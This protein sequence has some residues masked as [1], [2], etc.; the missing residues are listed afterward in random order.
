MLSK[1]LEQGFHHSAARL[2][3]GALYC[4]AV[5]FVVVE[6]STLAAVETAWRKRR[7]LITALI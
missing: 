2:A 4:T 3:S 1:T 6:G 5:K 7:Q